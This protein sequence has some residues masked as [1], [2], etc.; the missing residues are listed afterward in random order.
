MEKD[1]EISWNKGERNPC[2]KLK[3]QKLNG[4]VFSEQIEYD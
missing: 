4:S 3:P 1:Y 2:Q